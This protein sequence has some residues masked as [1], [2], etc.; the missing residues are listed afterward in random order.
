MKK[1]ILARSDQ[2]VEALAGKMLTYAIGR[3]MEPFDRPAIRAIARR[4]RA[5]GDRMTTL[6]ESV[7][8]SE[9][10]RTCRGRSQTR[11]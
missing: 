2:F 1:T 8:L 3:G 5:S 10:F 4:T 11:E 7:V 6:I 9:T